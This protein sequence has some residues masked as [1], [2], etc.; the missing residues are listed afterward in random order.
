MLDINLAELFTDFLRV[1][2]ILSGNH[3]LKESLVKNCFVQ[4][5][6]LFS[7]HSK[8]QDYLK[9]L[10]LLKVMK[11]LSFVEHND[12]VFDVLEKGDLYE[13]FKYLFGNDALSSTEKNNLVSELIDIVTVSYSSPT[14]V[15]RDVPKLLD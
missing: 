15:N 8:N 4:I 7:T 9:S 5:A 14:F 1:I 2:I 13:E 3:E 10:R 11:N 6:N 12:K